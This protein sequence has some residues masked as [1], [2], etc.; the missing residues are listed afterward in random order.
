MNYTIYKSAGDSYVL[1]ITVDA[2]AYEY[3]DEDILPF[4]EYEYYIEA[5]TIAG[6]TSGN[7][8]IIVT[9]EAGMCLNSRQ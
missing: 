3:I 6:A 7:S 8:S 2:S 1:L 9:Q 5:A 4:T